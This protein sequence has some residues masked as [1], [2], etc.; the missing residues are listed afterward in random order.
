MTILQKI[1]HNKQLITVILLVILIAITFETAQ[2]LYYVKRFNL[3]PDATFFELFKYQAY[4]WVVW[5]FVSYFLVIY[6]KNRAS[7]EYSI[8]LDFY[9]ITLLVLFLVF[10]DILI[11]SFIQALLAESP[12]SMLDIVNEYIPFFTFQKAPIYTL[13]YISVAIILHFYYANKQLQVEVLAL[14]ELKKVNADLY[15]KL[16]TTFT[17]KTS[18]LN[19]KIGKNRKII[20][21]DEIYWIEADDYCVRV[22]TFNSAAYAMRIS[23]KAL[24]QKLDHNFIRVHRNAIV[25][26]K[27][28]K[29]LQNGETQKLILKDQTE[30]AISKSKLKSV[31]EF[32]SSS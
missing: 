24:E 28:V 2:Q 32:L 25:N 17:D 12:F 21:V 6:T 11:I 26:M 5:A 9:K 4:R 8:P 16:S 31:K 20:P 14:G 19:I 1:S 27:M 10:I 22:H 30:V 18:V 29:E 3:S 15:E 13:G 7:K 23:L